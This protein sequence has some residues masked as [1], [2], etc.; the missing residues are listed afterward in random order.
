[1]VQH[2]HERRYEV[3]KGIGL[4]IGGLFLLL[5]TLGLVQKGISF[6]LIIIAV[7]IITYGAAISGLLDYGHRLLQRYHHK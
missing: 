1:M 2:N 3:L 6:M 7:I 5:Y 4:V